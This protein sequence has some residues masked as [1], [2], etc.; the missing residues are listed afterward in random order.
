MP[1]SL[2][3]RQILY[4]LLLPLAFLPQF[5]PLVLIVWSV[6]E[7]PKPSILK[8]KRAP[9]QIAAWCLRMKSLRPAW[10]YTHL[11]P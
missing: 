4:D 5:Q 6:L 3:G 11:E 2:F 10:K 7:L 8:S 1:S 9:L